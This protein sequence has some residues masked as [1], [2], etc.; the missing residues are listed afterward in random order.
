MEY[1]TTIKTPFTLSGPGLHT[2]KYIKATV[3][4]ADCGTGIVLRRIDVSPAVDIPALTDN[5]CATNHGTVVGIADMTVSTIEHMMS[6]FNG[7]GVDNAFVEVDGPEVPI[8]DGSAEL[9]VE[10]INRVGI[11]EQNAPK[12]WYIIHKKIEVRDDKGVIYTQQQ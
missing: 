8:L 1:Q 9:Y 10:H 11:V 12:D 4:P 6:A 3:K 2:G 5:V 7:L